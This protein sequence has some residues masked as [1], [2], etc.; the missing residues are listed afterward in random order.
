MEETT[1][2]GV[3][4]C[5]NC[6]AKLQPGAKFCDNCG[7]KI[8]YTG[9]PVFPPVSAEETQE[10][11][12]GFPAEEQEQAQGFPAEE[13]SQ[14]FPAEEQSQGFPE[15]PQE[16]TGSFSEEPHPYAGGTSQQGSTY[17]QGN[18]YQQ[19]SAYQQNNYQQNN[20]Q[21]NNYQQE[22]GRSSSNAVLPPKLGCALAYLFP[23]IGCVALYFLGDRENDFVRH[24]LNQAICLCIL[25][26]IRYAIHVDILQSLLSLILLFG[27]VVGMY[28]SITGKKTEIPLI[29]QVKII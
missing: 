6:G 20:Y 22:P 8:V 19:G 10:Q 15:E 1:N 14:G 18:T 13:Q 3:K 26:I 28:G 17:Q 9:E 29:S 21:Q 16:Q 5:E 2:G 27:F 7:Q 24:H 25:Q 4:F 12:Q 11:A 23:L